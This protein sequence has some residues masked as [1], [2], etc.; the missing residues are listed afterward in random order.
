VSCRENAVADPNRIIK[1]TFLSLSSAAD[2]DAD[3]TANVNV[4]TKTK[5]SKDPNSSVRYLAAKALLP[6]S[7]GYLV[8]RLEGLQGY[9]QL[10]T[11]DRSFGRLLVTTTERR[12]GQIDKVLELCQNDGVNA[13]RKLGRIDLYVQAVLR[14]GAVQ[15]LFLGVPPHAAVKE[16][17]DVLRLDKSIKVPESRIKFVNAVLRRLSREGTEL[18]ARHSLGYQPSKLQRMRTWVTK[19]LVASLSRHGRNSMSPRW[20]RSFF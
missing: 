2:A 11:R 19:R 13:K 15:L 12:L 1:R 7:T 16:T 3:D 14:V 4:A 6:G 17:V 10:P 20:T 18:L 9:K 8:D 5:V